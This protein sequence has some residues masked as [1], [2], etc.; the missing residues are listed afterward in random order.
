MNAAIRVDVTLRVTTVS[1][2]IDVAA[3]ALQ[4]DTVSTQLGQVIS[5]ESMTSLPLNGRSYTDLLALQPGVVP[6]AV[7]DLTSYSNAP[8]SG[9]LDDGSLSISGARGQSNGFMVNGGIVQEQLSNGTA[10]IPNIDSIA[11]SASSPTISMRRM[12]TTAEGS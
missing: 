2:T 12:A 8:P 4:V 7:T 11:D 5:G 1:E 3:N 10:I 6:A 9:G